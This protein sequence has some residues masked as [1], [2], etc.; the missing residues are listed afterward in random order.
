MFEYYAGYTSH[1]A[2]YAQMILTHWCALQITHFLLKVYMLAMLVKWNS[3]YSLHL[4]TK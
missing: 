3:T 4:K 1:Y 2:R